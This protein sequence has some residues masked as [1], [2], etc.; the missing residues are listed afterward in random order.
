MFIRANFNALSNNYKNLL[1]RKT[2]NIG[3]DLYVSI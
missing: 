1:N 2:E 3:A